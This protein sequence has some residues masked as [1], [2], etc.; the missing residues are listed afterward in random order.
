[1]TPKKTYG[2]TAS[3][4]VI[5]DKLVDDLAARAERG[6][7]VDEILRRRGGRPPIGSGPAGVGSVRLDPEL[8][9]AL[10]ARTA[11]D[12]A[13]AS[14]VIRAALRT[15]LE[16]SDPSSRP[17]GP[18]TEEVQKPRSS[19]PIP[20]PAPLR[21]LPFHGDAFDWRRFE[22]FCLD[23]VRALSDVQH[24]EVYGVPG[25]DQRGIDIVAGLVDDRVRTIQCRHRKRFTKSDAEKVVE[26]T[27]YAADEHE[28]WVTTRV[29]TAAADVLDG[30]DGWSYQSNEG[31]SQLVRSLRTEAA[32]KILDH[33]FG[34]P[35]RRAFLGGATSAFDESQA[36]F[37]PFD[38]PGRLIRHDLPLVGRGDELEAMRA[39]V[40]EPESR[41]VLQTGR[42]G[43]GKTRLLR[44]LASALELGGTRVMFARAGVELS[45]EA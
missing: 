26:E 20:E 22:T 10:A 14:S 41:V 34:P 19:V 6:H 11:R 3:G 31:I 44:A 23:V 32:R 15:Y 36:Y 1:M 35:V 28:V 17:S 30:H 33:A 16:G 38:Q 21:V 25:G 24:A 27:T 9:Q 5:D 4:K 40:E 37:A 2:K 39:A 45:A 42:G 29:G 18:V 8:R 43:I 12:Q 13:S 7:D